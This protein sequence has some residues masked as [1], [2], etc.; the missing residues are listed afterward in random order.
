MPTPPDA[1]YKLRQKEP[2]QTR[3][4]LRYDRTKAFQAVKIA[5]AATRNP[6]LP[7]R[8][9]YMAAV[10]VRSAAPTLTPRERKALGL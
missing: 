10:T 5:L 8:E 6:E 7:F 2:E 4:F 9:R 3:T 1:P